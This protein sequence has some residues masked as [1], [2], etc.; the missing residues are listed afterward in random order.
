MKYDIVIATV[1]FVYGI[2]QTGPALLK[3]SL[4]E[5][6]VSCKVIDWNLDI[7]NRFNDIINN[8]ALEYADGDMEKFC[9][10]NLES[11]T[12]DWIDEIRE[13]N[14]EWLGLSVYSSRT[15][16][17][18][19]KNICDLFRQEMPD[20]KIVAGGH[21]FSTQDNLGK[22]LLNSKAID[23]FIKGEGE[24]AIVSLLKNE[25]ETSAFNEILTNQI[26][27]LDSI[28]FPDYSDTKPISYPEEKVFIIT[29]RGCIRNCN[30]CMNYFEKIRFRSSDNVVSEMFDINQKYNITRFFFADSLSN[31]NPKKLEGIANT[32][33]KYNEDGTMPKITWGCSFCCLPKRSMNESLYKIIKKSGC[34]YINVG[35]ESGSYEVREDM[36]KKTKDEDV[37]FMMEQLANNKINID[38]NL[39][40]GYYTETE[41]EFQKTIDMITKLS[42][43]K[44]I[45]MSVNVGPTFI[46]N[47]SKRKQLD[48]KLDQ[49]GGWFYKENT[50][51]VRVDR[52][53]RLIDHCKITGFE[54]LINQKK[55]ILNKLEMYEKTNKMVELI[56]KVE[57]V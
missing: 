45:K 50:Y 20:I 7:Y 19:I 3:A 41:N 37:Y 24:E 11:I 9:F 5:A 57:T 53:L 31:G 22:L 4:I 36:N 25:K 48:I 28:P 26:Q 17:P 23:C 44:D 18:I 55:V 32:I 8:Q 42:S 10:D 51:P 1:P 30:F 6:G 12:L 27:D 2:P 49:G 13:F 43:I 35:I 21:A 33:I 29:S 52:W 56:E 15:S 54:V 38:M 47:K 34:N 16:M 14:P 46:L 40:V 39:I